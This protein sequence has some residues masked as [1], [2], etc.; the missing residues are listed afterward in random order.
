VY[1]KAV[2][3]ACTGL[4][5]EALLLLEERRRRDDL[6]DVRRSG[7]RRIKG[8]LPSV[9]LKA[10]TS[11]RQL[12]TVKGFTPIYG[13]SSEDAMKARASIDIGR[14]EELCVINARTIAG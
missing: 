5:R 7:R 14:V 12:M 2:D 11:K 10:Q 3:D 1:N 6:P 8:R 9:T 13:R 4:L